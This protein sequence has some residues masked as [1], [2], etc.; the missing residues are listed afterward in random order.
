MLNS[1]VNCFYKKYD[2]L[3]IRVILLWFY[4]TVLF[5]ESFN[6]K[7]KIDNDMGERKKKRKKEKKK[8]HNTK[9]SFYH[10]T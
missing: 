1:I 7:S 6:K 2:R 8:K 10:I 5:S 9:E 4:K 3:W